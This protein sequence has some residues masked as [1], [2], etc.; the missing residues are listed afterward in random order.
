[1]PRPLLS[2]VADFLGITSLNSVGRD[3]YIIITLRSLRMFTA[4]IPSLILALFFASLDFP[5]SRIGVFMTLTL[6]GDVMLSLLLTLVADKLG[7]RRILFM[8]SIMMAG[9]GV[10]FALSE[11]FWILLIAAVFG[12]ISVTGADCG[13][14]RA[15]EESILSGLTDEKTRSDV[16]S[17][18]VTATTMAGAIGAEVAGRTVQALEKR[19]ENI[20]KAFH[21]LFWAYAAFGIISSI[22]SL[23][24]SERCE[25]AGERKA[26]MA[27][28]GR[29]TRDGEEE[30]VLLEAMTPST[31]DGFEETGEHTQK[32]T[33]PPKKPS[34][35]SQISQST[36][37]IMYKLWILL[38]IDSLADG[39]TPYSLMNYY[40]DQKFHLSKATLGD[41]TSAS[42]FL[43]AVS[44]VFAGPLAKHIGLINTMVFTHL[45]SSIASAFIPLP[46]SVGWTIGFMLF[47]ASLN[48]MDQAPRTAFIAAVVKPEERT[49]VMGIT[50][51]LRTLAM[52]VG[53]SIT[54]LL[55]GNGTFWVAFLATGVCRIIYD[56]GLWVL[57]VNVKVTKDAGR[58]DDADSV[59]DEAWNGLLSDAES[60]ESEDERNSKDVEQGQKSI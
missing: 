57:F 45:P 53:P 15:V 50:S 7:R 32:R 33:E 48:S 35:F 25:A 26:E 16:L 12:I 43:C 6:L 11:S 18:Y 5:D 60:E 46:S 44:A 54:G 8:G 22:L 3:A 49:G 51:M 58:E 17:W 28:R 38:A 34:Y 14:F 40:V 10:V 1:M 23:G 27:E 42:Q 37:S 52:S 24:L 36:R 56:L 31:T 13:P 19:T 30:E 2:R 59:D 47:R 20:T 39:M 4:G 29:G 41:I 55:S 21:A 9:S